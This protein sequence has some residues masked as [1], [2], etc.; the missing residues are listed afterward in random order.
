MPYTLYRGAVNVVDGFGYDNVDIGTVGSLSSLLI[1][2]SGGLPLPADTVIN[3]YDGDMQLDSMVG[4][5][6]LLQLVS[7]AVWTTASLVYSTTTSTV[8]TIAVKTPGKRRMVANY[9]I[10]V[11]R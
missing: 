2:D 3:I 1:T 11:Y 9:A 10:A 7:L 6:I 4:S 5:M 8:L